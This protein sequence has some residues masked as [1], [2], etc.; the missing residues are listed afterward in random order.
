MKTTH[1]LGGKNRRRRR[2]LRNVLPDRVSYCD[3]LSMVFRGERS[4]VVLLHHFRIPH[5]ALLFFAITHFAFT[6]IF[7]ISFG[8]MCL[9]LA[10]KACPQNCRAVGVKLMASV[11]KAA[12]RCHYRAPGQC[13]EI[14]LIHFLLDKKC[15]L[16]TV[17]TVQVFNSELFPCPWGVYGV[18]SYRSG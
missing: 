17:D 11:K 16:W 14:Q 2:S 13:S 7:V 9:W 8:L 10:T 4:W 1:V 5:F 3:T 15:Q 12:R 18:V 6:L